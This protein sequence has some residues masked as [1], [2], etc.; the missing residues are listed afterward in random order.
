MRIAVYTLGCKVNQYESWAME[1]DFQRLDCTVVPWKD[2]A[3]LYLVNTCTVTSKAACQSRQMIRRLRRQRPSA[4]IIATGCHVQT[5]ASTVLESAGPGICLAGNEHKAIIA[6]TALKNQDCTGI[7]VTDISKQRH[8]S[9]LFVSHAPRGRTR[10]YLKIQD[11]CNAFCSYCIVP[12]ARGRSRSLEPDQVFRQI[13][14]FSAEGIKEVVITGIH[15]GCY[16]KDLEDSTDLFTLLRQ[17]CARFPRISFRLSSIEPTEISSRF[18]R[19]A[20]ETENFCRHF[21]ISLQSGSDR[22]LSAMNRHYSGSYFLE[23]LEVIAA[24]MPGCCIG[25]DVMTGFPVEE[26]ADF[27]KTVELI[28]KAPVSYVHAFPYSP[29]PGTVAAAMKTMCPPPEAKKRAAVIRQIGEQKRLSFY[30]SFLG[31]KTDLL[32]ERKDQKTGLFAGHTPNYIPVGVKSDRDI[33]NRR[34]RVVIRK[35]DRDSVYGELC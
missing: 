28:T 11:G 5:D 3:D 7:F 21:H 13:E 17:I 25:T 12:Y 26:Q 34:V 18:I 32:V 10:T 9:P 15:V 19:W 14:A 20:A 8:I 22:V 24:F 31:E 27:E 16:G 1:E 33:T 4:R 23:L 6:R 29:R 30:E 2:E 35:V